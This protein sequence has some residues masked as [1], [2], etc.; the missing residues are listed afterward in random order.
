M[1]LPIKEQIKN[2]IILAL[3]FL[4]IGALTFG[5]GYA[6][7]S[8]IEREAVVKRKWL[9]LEEMLNVIAIAESTPGPIALNAATYVG[10]KVAGFFGAF[11][12]SLCVMIPSVTIITILSATITKHF[13][14]PYVK[15]AF[16]GMRAGVAALIFNAVINLGKF[17]RKEKRPAVFAILF[18]SLTL[19]ILSAFRILPFDNIY[20]IIGTVIFGII[21]TLIKDSKNKIHFK[22]STPK[23][24][25]QSPKEDDN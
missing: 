3:T 13:E 11:V 14:N 4:K 12:A 22:P 6:M 7:I 25:D 19:G 17:L 23:E 9:N 24:S 20:I 2:I 15:W 16:Q 10:A 8:I 18:V 1:K 21:Y 5:G